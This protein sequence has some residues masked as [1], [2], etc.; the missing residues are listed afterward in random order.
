MSWS[1]LELSETT[2]ELLSKSAIEKHLV[3]RLV[4]LPLMPSDAECMD[5]ELETGGP[6]D[7]PPSK[8][9]K[10]VPYKLKESD[11]KMVYDSGTVIYTE[12]FKRSVWDYL[13]IHSLADGEKR[14]PEISHSVLYKWRRKAL[15]ER[16]E[17]VPQRHVESRKSLLADLKKERVEVDERERRYSEPPKVPKLKISLKMT[18]QQKEEPKTKVI[19]AL[20]DDLSVEKKVKVVTFALQNSTQKAAEHYNLK[21]GEVHSYM[22]QN[23]IRRLALDRIRNRVT[24]GSKGETKSREEILEIINLARKTNVERAA[25]QYSVMEGQVLKWLRMGAPSRP[26]IQCENGSTD[27]NTRN[28]FGIDFQM[29]VLDLARKQSLSRACKVFQVQPSIVQE[30][31]K[32][33][34][35]EEEVH[36]VVSYDED[37]QSR[38]IPR[39][40][41]AAPVDADE[42]EQLLYKHLQ[43]P[44]SR[45]RALDTGEMGMDTIVSI[46]KVALTAGSKVASIQFNI[47]RTTIATWI[48]RNSL[49]DLVKG[50]VRSSV[51]AR[52]SDPT[53]AQKQTPTL[54]MTNGNT[55]PITE[56]SARAFQRNLSLEKSRTPSPTPVMTNGD[57]LEMDEL[58]MD[59]NNNDSTVTSKEEP[60]NAKVEEQINGTV[61]CKKQFN[62][63]SDDNSAYVKLSVDQIETAKE[64]GISMRCLSRWLECRKHFVKLRKNRL[65]G[66]KG[67]S[68]KE[69]LMFRLEAVDY[70]QKEG[71]VFAAS[72]F[73]V[74]LGELNE[75]TNRRDSYMR[76]LLGGSSES[77]AL[78]ALDKVSDLLYEN[79]GI[80]R[81]Q[82]I[83]ERLGLDLKLANQFIQQLYASI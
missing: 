46:L 64:I 61:S 8:K 20:T 67:D 12:E 4:K 60:S 56:R 16:G 11:K 68:L 36:K 19:H 37:D 21:P 38:V 24:R 3:V 33:F 17:F 77:L 79:E 34:F 32:K 13:C 23:V 31:M 22:S 40:V 29:K 82:A 47:P 57:A 76:A 15:E 74:T 51:T 66:A 30:W 9:Q 72:V 78:V 55:S 70:A 2:K 42:L 54:P 48:T 63:D 28:D 83:A 80:A 39:E 18:Q 52:R 1:P 44:S 75:W 6:D 50:C 27:G 41:K 5:P 49:E 62:G 53:P 26:A 81:A 69:I 73:R 58:L 25:R 43:E 45:I 35:P 65:A 7:E 14:Y 59:A 10:I 71:R